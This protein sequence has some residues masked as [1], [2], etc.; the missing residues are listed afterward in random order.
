MKITKIIMGR[1]G[2]FF[3]IDN[4][5]IKITAHKWQ[6]IFAAERLFYQV[7]MPATAQQTQL[8]K[9]ADVQKHIDANPE[10]VSPTI[11]I[12]DPKKGHGFTFQT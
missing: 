7:D 3:E 1:R 11:A 4:P 5:R 8:P 2:R 10:T 6:I 9:L 12:E